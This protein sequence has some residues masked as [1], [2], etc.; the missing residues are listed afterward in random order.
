MERNEYLSVFYLIENI[1]CIPGF[2]GRMDVL[3]VPYVMFS[4]HF[5]HHLHFAF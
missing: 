3:I 1:L 5:I 2:D 4:N